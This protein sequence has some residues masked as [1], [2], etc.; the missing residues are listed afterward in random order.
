MA[1][2]IDEKGQ[3]VL[4]D[5]EFSYIQP[6]GHGEGQTSSQDENWYTDPKV[7]ALVHELYGGPPDLDPMSCAEANE[8]VQAKAYYTAE[9]DGLIRPWEGRLLFNP[10]WGGSDATSAKVRGV[11][12]LL[13]GYHC[14]DIEAC[15]CVLNSNALTTSW[16]APLLDF[17]VCIPPRRLRH[18]GPDGKG[19]SPNSGTVV[20]YLGGDVDRFADIF[21]DLGTVMI[22][23]QHFRGKE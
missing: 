15:V 3:L 7:V 6:K 17:P 19:G 13:A 14:G 12:K 11:G 20:I 10:P 8:V 2:I 9:L 1:D 18:W 5:E 4:F 21:A 16:M 23:L 22:P